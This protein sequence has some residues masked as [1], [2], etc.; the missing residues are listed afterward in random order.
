MYDIKQAHRKATWLAFIASMG[1]LVYGFEGM[2]MNGAVTAVKSQFSA[3]SLAVGLAGSSAILGGIVGA[4]GSGRLSDRTGRK[5]MLW[6]GAIL[7]IVEALGAPFASSLPMFDVFRFIGG[8]G[9]GAAT[10]VGPGYIAEI[11]PPEIRGRLVSFR[12]LEII[13]GL[14]IA[15]I[16]NFWIM[17]DAKGAAGITWL[18]LRAW[19]WMILIMIVP[20]GLYLLLSLCV[21]ESPRYLVGCGR[22]DE[23]GLVLRE[24]T[25][26]QDVADTVHEIQESLIEAK[27]GSSFRQLFRG[28]NRKFLRLVGVATAVA[29]FQQLTGI[30]VIFFFSNILWQSVGFS[31]SQ[32]F[33]VTLITS[34]VKLVAVLTGIAL[35]DRVGRKKLLVWGGILMSISLS[36]MALIFTLAPKVPSAGGYL[37]PDLSNNR[38]LGVVCIIVANLFVFGFAS[39]WGP[40]FSVLMGEMFPNRIR[41]A[42]MSVASGADFVFNYVVVTTF[43]MLLT[44][45]LGLTYWIYA[46]FGVLSVIFAARFLKE[47]KGMRLEEM[48]SLV[49]MK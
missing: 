20:A 45:S 22:A 41:G 36:A 38:A 15:S 26:Q 4:V 18:G 13:L 42:A 43:P 21:P 28:T 2:A 44:I 12:Q 25:G 1:G 3:G 48:E 35:I 49:E 31:Q 27:Q 17:S 29:A 30:N 33:L 39:T 16:A 34:I 32:S 24:V 40:I 14:L 47:T 8:I 9:V 7:L 46:A 5:A 37:Q 19:Q 10:T 23:A 11:S 6:S